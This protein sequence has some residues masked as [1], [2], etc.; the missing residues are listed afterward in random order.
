MTIM[1]R[2]QKSCLTE[3]S[4]SQIAIEYS[5][6]VQ[7]RSPL[8]YIFWIYAGEGQRFEQSYAGLAQRLKLSGADDPMIDSMW[9]VKLWLA[10]RD[11]GNWLMI[12]DN[13]DD[14]TVFSSSPT[15]ED[16]EPLATYL[17]QTQHGLILVTSRNR[18]A[19][20]DLVGDV[21]SL[22]SV[23]EMCQT[24]AVSLLRCKLARDRPHEGALEL[25]E[26]LSR[27]P[28]AITQAASYINVTAPRMSVPRYLNL[29]RKNQ[30]KYLEEVAPDLR[31]D[32]T[33][34]ASNSAIGTWRISF[35][36]IRNHN[37]TAGETLCFVSLLHW[38][39]IP[40]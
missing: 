29:F 13:V 10:D 21:D 5:Y 17:P 36:H 26:A 39:R 8:A 11:N 20:L 32:L 25:V 30:T 38:H 18:Q 31:R 3:L 23:P 24:E 15:N 6:R 28:L 37:P 7:E 9:L 14:E 2:C 27:M 16:R 33:R 35:D 4:K 34:S 22:V 12:L 40:L 19:A 1:L